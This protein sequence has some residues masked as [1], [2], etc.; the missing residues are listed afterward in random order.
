MGKGGQ[1]ANKNGHLDLNEPI[2]QLWN[3]DEDAI[4][5][6]LGDEDPAHTDPED[7]D[8][9]PN[10][11]SKPSKKRVK[12]HTPQ[13]IQE[14]MA[15]YEQCTHPD[16]EAMQALG[17]MIGL[18][19]KLVK[20]WFQ[21]RRSQVKK[22]DQQEQNQQF[23]QANASLKA[24]NRSLRK[25]ILTQTCVTCCGKT[26]PF[27]PLL[28]KQ[29]LLTKN[30]RLKDEFLR[31]FAIHSKII[32]D[33]AFTQPAPW[34]SSSSSSEADREALLR[35][36]E[37]SMEQFLVLAT[38]GEPMWLPAADGG[39]M[40]NHVEYRAKFSPALFRLRPEG[41]AVEATRDTAM[42]WGSAA[43]LVVIFMDMARWS[44]TFPGV[45]A[46]VVA[47][48]VVSTG[49]FA[50]GQIQLMNAEMW[51]Q[52]PRVPNRTVNI[53]RYSKLV[54]ERQ[55]AVM[56]VSVDGI[57]GQEVLP[58]YLPARYMGCRLLPSGC[59]LEDMSN[60]YCKVTWIV[61]AEYDETTMPTVFKPLFLNG[62]AL[63]A[64][65]WLTSLQ[66]QREYA[67]ALHSS[68]YPGNNN[69]AA[70]AAGMLKL[71]QQMMASFYATV[72]GPI[73]QSQATIS[74]ND[75]FGSIGTGVE[76]FDV[77]VRM[78]TWE[79]AGSSVAGEPASW[80]LSATT[81]LWLPGTPPERV[82]DYLRNEQRR[83]EWDFVHTNGAV[84]EEM[85]SVSMG[86]LAGNVTSILSSN[87]T[88]GTNDRTLILQEA[89]TDASGSLVVYTPI[90]EEAMDAAMGGGDGASDFPTPSGFAILPDG[91][92]K[93]CHAP[94]PAPSTSSSAP[95]LRN[96]T[97]GSLV[98]MAYQVLLPGPLPDTA[99]GA[100][101]D[102]GKLMCH[103]MEKIKNAVE[104][105][106]VLPA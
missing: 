56:D 7:E 52:S 18:A 48:D 65:R 75:W 36:A 24:E 46:S 60:G 78:V 92:G 12:R 13:Q 17:T 84:V 99:A 68:L 89:R 103:V 93:A 72:S 16:P 94:S 90:G 44:E 54:A 50:D 71:A 102:V 6:I 101:D 22:K 76:R 88:D 20:F 19:P 64:C 21:N 98:T 2:P 83:G 51:V 105:E 15:A 45:V 3:N 62:K 66:R 35:H 74:I 37:T 67:T 106:I 5:D 49:S 28:E 1:Q 29:Q 87:K 4:D 38:K 63:G 47:G 53:L 77:A 59:L 40:L 91:R 41:F 43:E 34:I 96:D 100:F 82:F 69:T 33:S 8:Y 23:Q 26:L 57:F 79:K 97:G 9:F 58:A 61:H 86:Y 70:E 85:S 10:R 14:L 42:V 104:A 25:A 30:A 55:W 73:A 32:R 27:N 39:E 81:T 31:A 80:F 95:V 11:R